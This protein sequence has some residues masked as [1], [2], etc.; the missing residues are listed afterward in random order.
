M[1][2]TLPAALA[3]FLAIATPC[4]DPTSPPA[5][6]TPASAPSG[7]GG[8]GGAGGRG[9]MGRGPRAG[10]GGQSQ[11]P[12]AG[13]HGPQNPGQKPG[14]GPKGPRL[15]PLSSQYIETETMDPSADRVVVKLKSG[16]SFAGRLV[17]KTD[18]KVRLAIVSPDAK[19][20]KDSKEI[21][22]FAAADVESTTKVEP[23]VI[24]EPMLAQLGAPALDKL[25]GL[26][27][28][29]FSRF[30]S[31]G[32]ILTKEEPKTRTFLNARL[33][34]RVD[35]ISRS[36]VHPAR[37]KPEEFAVIENGTDRFFL[38]NRVKVL[39]S[40]EIE[41]QA[42]AEYRIE[43]VLFLAP[44]I[45][46][47]YGTNPEYL[48]AATLET[49]EPKKYEMPPPGYKW[50]SHQKGTTTIDGSNADPTKA[51]TGDDA[52]VERPSF[53]WADYQPVQREYDAVRFHMSDEWAN[54]C[55]D[56][57]TLML[58]RN[59]GH[60]L[61][62]KFEPS[63]RVRPEHVGKGV[64]T[65]WYIETQKVGKATFPKLVDVSLEGSALRRERMEFAATGIAL[66]PG[67]QE[68]DLARP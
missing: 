31:N 34:G 60:V 59:D 67:L 5:G 54:A 1:L 57:L 38:R 13:E 46:Q 56:S 3:A 47:K 32:R 39:S 7:P 9:P 17:E 2:S 35:T 49:F 41:K 65:Y 43:L 24:L 55:G 63:D 44:W 50:P 53:G 27:F 11:R 61:G 28:S 12:G 10:K 62:F 58:D 8:A 16:E 19:D 6:D 26:T 22:E 23:H 20:T 64:E 42:S 45:A 52:E 29:R 48:G 66:E 15:D 37:G 18:A 40:P 30:W 21:K 51:D 4:Q 36:A 14:T 68:A 33:A 25:E